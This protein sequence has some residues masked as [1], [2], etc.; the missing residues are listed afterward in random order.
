MRGEWLS[1]SHQGRVII[2]ARHEEV[3]RVILVG[4]FNFIR[5]LQLQGDLLGPQVS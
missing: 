3:V 4:Y 1:L 5:L 2:D